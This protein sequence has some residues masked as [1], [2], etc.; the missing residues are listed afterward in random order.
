MQYM[1]L[2]YQDEKKLDALSQDEM[3]A[4]VGACVGWV[5]QLEKSGHHIF[6][7][8][9]QCVRT[10][11]TV[12]HRDGKVSQTDGPFAETKEFLG[13]FTLIN[14]RDKNEAIHLASTFPAAHLGSMEVRPV[15]EGDGELSDA[16]DKKIGAAFRRKHAAGIDPT[17][18]SRFAS[19][20]Q[21]NP[22]RES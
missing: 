6:S 18:A 19:I 16:L 15:L 20:P 1:C 9:L 5:D 2:V 4:V 13:G 10:A 3:D 12:R 11:A 14:A 21:P 8:G 22:A 17:T 7:A